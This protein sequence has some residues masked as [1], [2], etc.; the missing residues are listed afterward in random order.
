[1]ECDVL[2]RPGSLDFLYM[3]RK[4]VTIAARHSTQFLAEYKLALSSP[5]ASDRHRRGRVEQRRASLFASHLLQLKTISQIHGTANRTTQQSQLAA[6]ASEV[7]ASLARGGKP[8]IRRS[9]A[10]QRFM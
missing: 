1:M 10:R 6:P 4:S 2:V 9:S 7:S 5:Q 8:V 3:L